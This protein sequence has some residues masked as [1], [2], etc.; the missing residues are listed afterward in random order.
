MA[1]VNEFMLLRLSRL[2]RD[3]DDVSGS[4]MTSL[5]NLEEFSTLI[6]NYTNFELLPESEI[7]IEITALP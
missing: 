1:I 3:Q 7:S 5:I 6:Q 2:A 4:Q